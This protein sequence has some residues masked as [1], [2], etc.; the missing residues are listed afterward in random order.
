[1]GHETNGDAV[2]TDTHT[3]VSVV[4]KKKESKSTNPVIDQLKSN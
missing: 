3:P 4:V 2:D 1:M